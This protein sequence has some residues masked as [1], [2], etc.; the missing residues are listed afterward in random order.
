MN[1]Y[2]KY[3]AARL[4]MLERQNRWLTIIAV[5]T[6]IILLIAATGGPVV[7]RATSLQLVDEDDNVRAELSLNDDAVGLYIKGELGDDRL[8]AIHDARST[9][10]Y[11]NDDKG[12]TRIGIARFAHGVGGV[13]PHGAE[14]KGAAVIYVKEQG[15]LRYFDADG[16]VTNQMVASKVDR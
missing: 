3:T 12:T 11:V 8:L 1:K 2:M 15:S 7:I 16:S 13:A 5:T 9:G 14:A 4:E 10:F 6:I